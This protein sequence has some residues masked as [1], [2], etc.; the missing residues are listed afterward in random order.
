MTNFDQREKFKDDE[1]KHKNF[2]EKQSRD[3]QL[4]EE[5]LRK[6]LERKQERDMDQLLVRKIKEELDN[7]QNQQLN[8]TT[9]VN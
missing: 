4:Y 9:V 3:K 1:K 6:K 8:K 5:N 7:E 2:Q